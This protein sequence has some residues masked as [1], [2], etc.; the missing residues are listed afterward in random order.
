MTAANDTA[1]SG[2]VR[3]QAVRFVTDDPAPLVAFYDTLLGTSTTRAVHRDSDG[4]RGARGD[5]RR[6][7]DDVDAH[8]SGLESLRSRS[9][10]EIG[11]LA[12]EAAHA[13]DDIARSLDNP[14]AGATPGIG[15][16]ASKPGTRAPRVVRHVG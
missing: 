16:V 11:K 15:Q 6:R 14:L 2:Q 9:R 13:R 7:V 3:V 10:S 1:K 4:D 5:P 8:V 12:T